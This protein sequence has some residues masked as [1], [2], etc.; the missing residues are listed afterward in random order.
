MKE[1]TKC[2]IFNGDVIKEYIE[3]T[4]DDLDKMFNSSKTK[5]MMEA[6][7]LVMVTPVQALLHA[8][9]NSKRIDGERLKK[10]LDIVSI[11]YVDKEGKSAYSFDYLKEGKKE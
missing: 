3:G 8:L 5:E 2:F 11:N 1:E 4:K 6:K 10:F 9:F 7:F